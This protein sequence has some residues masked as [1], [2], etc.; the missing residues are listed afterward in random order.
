MELAGTD[1]SRRLHEN[2]P[3]HVSNSVQI[4]DMNNSESE[5][6]I[7]NNETSAGRESKSRKCKEKWSATTK[8]KLGTGKDNSA[9]VTRREL[10]T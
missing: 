7:G 6:L 4:L 8:G 2:Q 3:L 9:R 1:G 10:I 5:D